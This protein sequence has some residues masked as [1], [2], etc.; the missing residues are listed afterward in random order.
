MA[1]MTAVMSCWKRNE[2]SDIPCRKEIQAFAK[3]METN[4]RF[5]LPKLYILKLLLLA[6]SVSNVCNYGGR[7]LGDLIT[8]GR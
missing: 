3:C 7:K 6:F 5:S 4:V 2:F 1:Q 8:S